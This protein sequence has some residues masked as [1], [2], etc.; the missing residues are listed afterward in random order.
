MTRA[1]L[2]IDEKIAAN[3]ALGQKCPTCYAAPGTWCKRP[4]GHRAMDLHRA[5]LLPALP[6]IGQPETAPVAP[7]PSSPIDN[8]GDKRPER[9]DP[10]DETI[11]VTLRIPARYVRELDRLAADVETTRSAWARHALLE[12]IDPFGTLRAYE[13]ADA[14][15]EAPA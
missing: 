4:S 3:P 13:H 11:V 9:V 15:E 8:F 10:T 12:A 1:R 14:A 7:R 5:R 2:T 6:P